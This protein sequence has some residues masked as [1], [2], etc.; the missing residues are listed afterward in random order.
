MK[1]IGIIGAGASGL[2]AA[3][4]LA[5]ESTD[6]TLLEKNDSIGKKLLMTGNGRCNIT[7]A[8]FYDEL[9]DNIVRN[10][11]FMFSSFSMHDT[12]STMY[13]YQSNGIELLTE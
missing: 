1:K 10:K 7:N 3:L 6:I 8:M 5:N 13:F 4:N 11:T 2:Y 12:Y 9:L